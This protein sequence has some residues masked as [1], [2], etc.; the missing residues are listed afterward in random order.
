MSL[1][2][3]LCLLFSL[4]HL[5]SHAD[6]KYSPIKVK[7]INKTNKS[8]CYAIDNFKYLDDSRAWKSLFATEII[9]EIADYTSKYGYLELQIRDISGNL[10]ASYIPSGNNTEV[11][12]IINDD[13]E[14]PKVTRYVGLRDL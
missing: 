9:Y 3:I 12:I 10:V 1:K 14:L 2:K 7:I 11:T 5:A 13:K 6:K 4:F 8:L